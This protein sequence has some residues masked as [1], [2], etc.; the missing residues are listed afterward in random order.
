MLF[1]DQ[2]ICFFN[3]VFDENENQTREG[4]ADYLLKGGDWRARAV[5]ST[6]FLY[7]SRAS[8]MV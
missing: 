2:S 3:D 5:K 6:S 8:A 1:S 7:K 4:L